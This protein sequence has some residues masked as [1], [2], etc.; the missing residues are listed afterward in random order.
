MTFAE[1]QTEV[2]RRLRE[3][4]CSGVYFSTYDI[5]DAINAGYM[6]ASDAT[7]WLEEYLEI[8]LLKARPYYD[9][10]TLI[11]CNFLSIKPIFDEGSNRWLRPSNVRGLDN[12]DRRWERVVGT[13]Q[14][15]VLRGLRWLGLFPR[16]NA[17]SGVEKLY[18]TRLPEPLCADD[19]EPGFPEAY[20]TLC[21]DFALADLWAQDA[22][23]KLALGAWGDY[24]E[25]EGKLQLWVNGREA[26]PLTRVLGGTGER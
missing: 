14:R 6:E 4:S 16:T 24:L 19:D 12:C 23:S 26:R 20:H 8:D 9:L 17:D 2:F 13:P 11:G 25:G 5:Q 1:M 22:E 10:F 18:Y 3:A 21:V 7:E 15:F